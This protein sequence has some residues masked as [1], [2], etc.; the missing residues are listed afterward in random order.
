M[1]GG[2]RARK[3]AL[4]LLLLALCATQVGLLAQFSS[5]PS[6]VKQFTHELRVALNE[7]KRS[8]LVET[9]AILQE[10]DGSIG[11]HETYTAAIVATL[12]LLDSLNAIDVEKAVEYIRSR[13]DSE[14]GAFSVWRTSNGTVYGIDL[15]GNS[16]VVK[17]L[18]DIDALNC[19]E[20]EKLVSFVLSCYNRSSGGFQQP[21]FYAY[22]VK[23]AVSAF[24]I[25]FHN[26]S[27][28][29]VAYEKPNI[30]S[31]YCALSVLHDLGA[32][33]SIDASK[34]LNFVLSCRNSLGIFTP[35][36]GYEELGWWEELF[37]TDAHGGGLPYLYAGVMSLKILGRLDLL[38]EQE[39]RTMFQYVN[40]CVTELGDVRTYPGHW[41]GPDAIPYA[42]FASSII[43]ELGFAGEAQGLVDR[44][45]NFIMRRQRIGG[46][47]RY[48]PTDG[49][50]P[51]P[52]GRKYIG[53][54]LYGLFTPLRTVHR[55]LLRRADA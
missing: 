53:K 16:L 37:P 6:S 50:W 30:I 40:A 49:S 9:C 42:Y 7:T 19:I 51:I 23:Y 29:D 5:L 2:T 55:Y 3:I 4:S 13:Q 18:R 12:A 34:T 10:E 52:E 38:S 28:A 41:W 44:I 15:Y 31:T 36:P 54:K 25:L 43:Y 32:L 48:P 17:C 14:Y 22:G 8:A 24:P 46:N 47:L 21:V 1:E 27:F 35:F 26:A 45:I 39:R 20:E 11:K 33:S